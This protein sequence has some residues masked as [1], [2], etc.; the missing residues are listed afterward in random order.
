[1]LYRMER[2]KRPRGGI[3]LFALLA[4]I[5]AS[6]SRCAEIDEK[7]FPIPLGE[8]EDVLSP[9]LKEA[10]YT[11][12]RTPLSMGEVEL[13]TQRGQADI[14]IILQPHSPL[15]TSIRLEYEKGDGSSET[16]KRDLWQHLEKYILSLGS[17]SSQLNEDDSNKLPVQA[18]SIVCI[19]VTTPLRK[20]QFT[21]FIIDKQGLIITIAHGLEDAHNISITTS[22]G[23]EYK[24]SLIKADHVRD[25]ALLRMQGEVFN[26]ISLTTARNNIRPDETLYAIGFSSPSKTTV[27]SGKIFNTPRRV[28]GVP[29]WQINMEIRP[30]SSGSPVFNAAGELTAVVK[31]RLRGSDS[32]G[33][34]IP[35]AVLS[36]FLT[37]LKSYELRPLSDH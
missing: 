13:L 23:R 17:E 19:V 12:S 9:W 30:G 2:M 22:Q 8:L 26:F 28:N 36:D 35:F 37:T 29:L 25:L 7:I 34:L 20:E 6:D 18:K 1:M 10:G 16:L 5:I 27:H 14:H 33:F 15:A 4:L 24:G 31:G 11:L 3:I 32:I 21:G